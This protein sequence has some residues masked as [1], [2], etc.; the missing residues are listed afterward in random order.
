MIVDAKN[1]LQAEIRRLE[2]LY[3]VSVSLYAGE[4]N[5]RYR[6]TASASAQPIVLK[7]GN[8]E[9]EVA[10]NVGHYWQVVTKLSW[11]SVKWRRDVLR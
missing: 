7:H 2:T 11:L 6:Q 8:W 3:F 4:A 1:K 10:H 5:A 9:R